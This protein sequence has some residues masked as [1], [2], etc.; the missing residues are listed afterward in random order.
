MRARRSSL[1]RSREPTL[2][3]CKGASGPAT[4]PTARRFSRRTATPAAKLDAIEARSY[5]DL[6]PML[7]PEENARLTR[8][9]PGTPMGETFRRYWL[10]AALSEELPEPDGAPVRVRLLG[11]DLVAFRDSDGQ[12][13]PGRRLLPASARAAVLRP[14]RRV[15]AA[16]RLSRLE[17]RRD[18]AC[19]DMPSE[20]PDSLFKDKVRITSLSDVGRRRHRLGLPR[21]AG[22]HA[23][24][25]RFR[26][27]A[28]ARDAPLSSRRRSRTATGCRRS[29][30]A[31]TPRTR[32]SCTT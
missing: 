27:G 32:R 20:P 3:A 26:V 25:A 30:A 7:S 17:V 31:S 18:G 14:Q 1:A 19:V 15:R 23:G 28:R 8:V 2:S 10:P 21:A 13:R 29:K 11:E 24:A 22:A 12:R 4:L 6:V 9:G 5:A 16:L